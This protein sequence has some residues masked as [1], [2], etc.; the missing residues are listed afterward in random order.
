MN[1][2]YAIS[3]YGSYRRFGVAVPR[4]FLT[5]P[6]NIVPKPYREIQYNGDVAS[7]VPFL[8]WR[9]WMFNILR[10][11]FPR[12]H[13]NFSPLLFPSAFWIGGLPKILQHAT[14]SSPTAYYKMEEASG[15]RFDETAN[16]HDL[17]D[18]NTVGQAVGKVDNAADLVAANGEYFS[19]ADNADWSSGSKDMSWS[20]WAYWESGDSALLEKGAG[21]AFWSDIEYTGRRH[22]SEW[23]V[24][25][26]DTAT[27]CNSGGSTGAWILRALGIDNTNGKIFSSL[28]GGSKVETVTTK[29][30]FN[31]TGQVTIGRSY[32]WTGGGA[33]WDGQLDEFGF[34]NN[35]AFSQSEI[36]DLYNGGDGMSY[37]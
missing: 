34:W 8:P 22:G 21:G 28:N 20:W 33:Y 6:K 2:S 30:G 4:P 1:I 27:D 14:L 29:L 32:L 5:M 25:D 13:Q 31:G 36:D 26:G 19:L 7:R 37:D 15:T 35:K 18:N 3:R 11:G 24:S 9:V 23:W 16:N 17:T 12:S 10:D